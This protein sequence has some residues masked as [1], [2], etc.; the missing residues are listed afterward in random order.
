MRANSTEKKLPLQLILQSNTCKKRR[1]SVGEVVF[2]CFQVGGHLC[3]RP[4]GVLLKGHHDVVLVHV[5]PVHST[6]AMEL[7]AELRQVVRFDPVL[8]RVRFLF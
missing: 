5:Q 3:F 8:D 6:D 2:V 1:G 7:H 4:T